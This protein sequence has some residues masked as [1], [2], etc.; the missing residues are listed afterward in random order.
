MQ[1]FAYVY[2]SIGGSDFTKIPPEHLQDF[3]Y[4]RVTLNSGNKAEF[5]VYDKTAVMLE[6]QIVE[7]KLDDVTFY[8]GWYNGTESRKYRCILED[9]NINFDDQGAT[10]SVIATSIAVNDHS[11]PRTKTWVDDNE[12]PY[13]PS[14]IVELMV[15]DNDDW[16]MTDDS[17]E[18]TLAP[19]V[20]G[21]EEQMV[22]VQEG[23]SDTKFIIEK[24]LRNSVSRDGEKGSYNLFFT[25]TQEGQIVNFKPINYD[26]KPK[27]TYT[28]EWRAENSR[29][30]SFDPDYGGSD[31]LFYGGNKVEVNGVNTE[32]N[33]YIH[34]V[35]DKDVNPDRT[36]AERKIVKDTGQKQYLNVSSGYQKE[37]NRASKNLFRRY[38]DMLYKAS[39][40][41]VGDPELQPFESI[42]VLVFLMDGKRHHTSGIY[43]IVSISDTISGG[44]MESK[45]SM[46]RNSSIKG[47]RNAGGPKAGE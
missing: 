44:F 8:Y 40:T 12:N 1:K 31:A 38:N 28:Y 43:Y 2:I 6:N 11:K 3:S 14:E 37:I 17:I 39:M 23:I 13:T 7:S 4:E 20:E 46:I 30:I 22:F 5:T 41:I 10:L 24:L 16:T 34:H 19:E 9:Y 35:A 29:V 36:V 21:E 47:E 45:I 42:V 15:E 32:S 18:P 33:D 25:D 26:K 27:D